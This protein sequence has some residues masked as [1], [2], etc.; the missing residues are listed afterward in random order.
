MTNLPLA[1][2]ALVAGLLLTAAWTDIREFKIPN[3]ISLAIIALYLIRVLLFEAILQIPSG[4]FGWLS[5]VYDIGLATLVLVVGFALY[6][7]SWFGAGDVKL[8]TAATLWFGF[9]PPPFN[10]WFILLTMLFGG[11][12]AVLIVA[13]LWLRKRP[14]LDRALGWLD[15][16]RTYMPY[17]LAITAAGLI[18]L[19]KQASLYLQ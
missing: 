9:G 3:W 11:I 15:A 7:V 14:P 8:M 6:A 17:G 13:G 10:V 1:L 19:F 18:I 16:Y 12:L 5:L 2:H 4:A